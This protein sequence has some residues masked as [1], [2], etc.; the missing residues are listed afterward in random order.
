MYKRKSHKSNRPYVSPSE[1]RNLHYLNNLKDTLEA[2]QTKASSILFR[3][4]LLE[5]QNKMNYTTELSRIRGELSQT[6]L[7][8]QT[9]LELLERKK[10]LEKLGGE[11]VDRIN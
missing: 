7:P 5:H 3:K 2:N 8:Y 1:H 11:I 9:R 10:R 6:N 4:Q